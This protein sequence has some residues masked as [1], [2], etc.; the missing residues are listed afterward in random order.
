MIRMLCI[1]VARGGTYGTQ[2]A[3]IREH[4]PRLGPVRLYASM[5]VSIKFVIIA[6]TL[7]MAFFKFERA[8]TSCHN[9][10]FVSALGLV[11]DYI[12]IHWTGVFVCLRRHV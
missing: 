12:A 4:M 8:R 11:R 6:K 9:D 3:R 1:V 7:W 10:T 2:L 5:R